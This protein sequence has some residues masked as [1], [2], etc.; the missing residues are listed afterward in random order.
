MFIQTRA[1]FMKALR[2][3]DQNQT[4]KRR[5]SLEKI[6]IIKNLKSDQRNTLK[7]IAAALGVGLGTVAKHTQGIANQRRP[8]KTIS[9]NARSGLRVGGKKRKG[10]RLAA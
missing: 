9:I 10:L 3:L 5:I 4:D 2:Y 8:N 6:E 1:E 7:D